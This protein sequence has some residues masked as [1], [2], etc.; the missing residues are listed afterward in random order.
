[1]TPYVNDKLGLTSDSRTIV[2]VNQSIFFPTSLL[3]I[4]FI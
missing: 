3:Y 2:T 4:T 1:M